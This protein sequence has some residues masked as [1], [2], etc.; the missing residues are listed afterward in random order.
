[1]TK[2]VQDN[3]AITLA[4]ERSPHKALIRELM[5]NGSHTDLNRVDPVSVGRDIAS[6]DKD[7]RYLFRDVGHSRMFP[8]SGHWGWGNADI[9]VLFG[10]HP[11][12]QV[13]AAS[14][15]LGTG[16]RTDPRRAG[17]IRY[18]PDMEVA[19]EDTLLVIDGTARRDVRVGFDVDFAVPANFWPFRADTSPYRPDAKGRRPEVGFVFGMRNIYAEPEKDPKTQ[20]E[21]IVRPC[22]ALAVIVGDSG[23]RLEE[24]VQDGEGNA[25][26]G[27]THRGMKFAHKELGRQAVDLRRARILKTSFEVTGD[28]VNATVNGKVYSFPVPKDHQGFYGVGFAGNGFA[29]VRA[30]KVSAK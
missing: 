7:P 21:V 11:V 20:K 2:Q 10:D 12:W 19:D 26:A 23:I 28:K 17:A 16:P 8:E 27:V 14:F 22:R 25:W 6:F 9:F 30:L 29:E 3:R 18:A 24:L 15:A 1:V 4:L 5:A 13:Q